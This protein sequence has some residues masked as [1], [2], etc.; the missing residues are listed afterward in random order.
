MA[1]DP[2]GCLERRRGAPAGRSVDNQPALL[3][4]SPPEAPPPTPQAPCRR[5][6]VAPASLRTFLSPEAICAGAA[7]PRSEDDQHLPW[8]DRG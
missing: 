3:S 6:Y 8:P 7:G 5:T 2:K 1:H 4:H